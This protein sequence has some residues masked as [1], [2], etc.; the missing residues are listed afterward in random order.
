MAEVQKLELQAV[1]GFDGSVKNGLIYHPNGRLIIYPLGTTLVVKNIVSDT[2]HFLRG[3]SDNISCVALSNNGDL[4]ASGQQT[5]MGFQADVILWDLQ[6][7]KLM[8]RMKLHKVRVVDVAF[9]MNDTLL[10]SIGGRDDGR[11]I[12]WNTK[13]GKPIREERTKQATCVKWFN[14]DAERIFTGGIA[15]SQ[16]GYKS[17][18]NSGGKMAHQP[19][20]IGQL[21]R[22]ITCI[23]LD[24]EDKYAY[25]GTKS[26]DI[27]CIYN[28]AAKFK[29]LFRHKQFGRQGVQC[30]LYCEDNGQNFLLAGCGDGTVALIVVKAD[31]GMS[32]Q[33]IVEFSGS[34][35][36]IS[37]GV[38]YRG[39]LD[40]FVGT[41]TGN[42]YIMN[43]LTLQYEL[44]GTSHHSKITDIVFPLLS[45][46]LF[47]TCSKNDIRIWNCAKRQELL[48]IQVPNIT[49]NCIC[50]DPLGRTILSGWC[51]S[52]I[53][54]FL[55]KS[56]KLDYVINDAHQGDVTAVICTNNPDEETGRYSVISGGSDG[57][58]RI[59]K[60]T[61]MLASLKEH[62][63]AVMEIKITKDDSQLVSAS[64]DGSCIIWD[65]HRHVR[66][67]A[68]FD[69]TMF[70]SVV[71][72]PD[73]SQLLTCGSDRK[74]TYWDATDGPIRVVE[75]SESEIN[76]LDIEPDGVVFVSGAN[77]KLVKVW[78]YDGGN[79]LATGEGHSSGITRLKISP[80][81]QRIVSVG[82]EGAIF[83]WKMLEEGARD[84]V[85]EARDRGETYNPKANVED[86][87]DDDLAQYQENSK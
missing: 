4:L 16:W 61:N 48:R 65:F 26:G 5:H 73:E 66:L 1:I 6:N 40:T 14:N 50:L 57:R 68:F 7:L 11:V 44:R 84:L 45:S 21:K 39:G 52:K 86:E 28:P 63:G 53:R 29:N 32:L 8:Y 59:W 67:N 41:S 20:D 85:K 75:A 71:Y 13:D 69:T 33:R 9:N 37:K 3:H 38:D 80:N 64:A 24:M 12:V 17:Q 35:T 46:D 31:G 72:H 19:C 30:I 77:D 78:N 2:Q 23:T 87:V 27:L 82:A 15:A 79:L 36:S 54:A 60:G 81:Q 51:D 42:Q 56:G 76:A 47:I 10:A 55:P 43:S 22:T 25:C 83:I 49:C 58:V 18:R 62:K 74:I 34:V 70:K